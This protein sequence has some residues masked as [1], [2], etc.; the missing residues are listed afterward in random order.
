MLEMLTDL[1]I[2]QNTKLNRSITVGVSC[3]RDL[4]FSSVLRSQLFT[5]GVSSSFQDFRLYPLIKETTITSLKAWENQIFGKIFSVWKPVLWHMT[6]TVPLIVCFFSIFKFFLKNVWSQFDDKIWQA[7]GPL[8]A[9]VPHLHVPDTRQAASD[10]GP[11]PWVISFNWPQLV[12]GFFSIFNPEMI[13]SLGGS[14]M[15]QPLLSLIHSLTLNIR[16][17]L[18]LEPTCWQ[19]IKQVLP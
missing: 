5:P 3:D 1:K 14:A 17:F 8:P 9:G 13:C 12:T 7:W 11:P 10:L 6:P 19:E 18:L 16:S 2:R 4:T 15:G